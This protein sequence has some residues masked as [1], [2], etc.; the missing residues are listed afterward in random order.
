M[1]FESPSKLPTLQSHHLVFVLIGIILA[2]KVDVG[3]CYR[4]D[5]MFGDGDL[6]VYLPK[7]STT[8]LKLPKGLLAK[9]TQ[10]FYPNSCRNCS[11]LMGSLALGF[12][13][14][15]ALKRLWL[16]LKPKWYAQND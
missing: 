16:L 14:N 1:H 5:S 3:V 9:T 10:G 7:D 12:S 15:F 2:S 13:Q 11:Y 8:D 6:W 4:H